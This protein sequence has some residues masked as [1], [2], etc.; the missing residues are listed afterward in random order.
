MLYNQPINIYPFQPLAD[1]DLADLKVAL[2]GFL[3]KSETIKL[4]TKVQAM[5]EARNLQ[6]AILTLV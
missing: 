6:M 1:A 3:K 4:E 2:K 5:N